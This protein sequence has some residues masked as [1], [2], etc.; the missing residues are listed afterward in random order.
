LRDCHMTVGS[1]PMQSVG[2]FRVPLKHSENIEIATNMHCTFKHHQ[3]FGAFQNCFSW[4][5]SNWFNFGNVFEMHFHMLFQN[6]WIQVGFWNVSNSTLQ[7]K[8]IE[9]LSIVNSVIVHYYWSYDSQLC[10][11]VNSIKHSRP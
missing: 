10:G 8:C 6:I 5:V 7:L 3:I 4:N 9:N 11:E 2:E 1:T